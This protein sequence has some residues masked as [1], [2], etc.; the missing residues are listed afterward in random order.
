[1]S[2]ESI[3]GCL[4]LLMATNNIS[5]TIKCER[6]YIIDLAIA[7]IVEPLGPKY[8]KYDANS[9]YTGYPLKYIP[10]HIGLFSFFCACI[11]NLC[12][13]M[14]YI[15]PYCLRFVHRHWGSKVTLS[16]NILLIRQ[17]QIQQTIKHGSAYNMTVEEV[18]HINNINLTHALDGDIQEQ[19]ASGYWQVHCGH[20]HIIT[21]KRFLYCWHFVRESIPYRWIPVTKG[22]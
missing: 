22:E 13:F 7:Y 14:L 8:L 15:Y 19:K 12:G 3:H 5:F 20:N 9:T 10:T 6:S 17:N 21:W 11:D 16:V 1:M 2:T 18:T 4:S